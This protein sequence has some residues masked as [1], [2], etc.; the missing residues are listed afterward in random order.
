MRPFALAVLLS[1]AGAAP[2]RSAS[3]ARADL[4]RRFPYGTEN[5]RNVGSCHAFATVSLFEAAI[6]QY[7]GVKVHLSQSDLFVSD[8]VFG[9]T[10]AGL[11]SSMQDARAVLPDVTYVRTKGL[12]TFA[13]APYDEGFLNR[14]ERYRETYRAGFDKDPT[15]TA[16]DHFNN[17]LKIRTFLLG[18]VRSDSRDTRRA[19][20]AADAQRRLIS[21]ATKPFRVRTASEFGARDTGWDDWLQNALCEGHPVAMSANIGCSQAFDCSGKFSLHVFDVVGFEGG[22]DPVYLVRNSWGDDDYRKLTLA[23]LKPVLGALYLE[24]PESAPDGGVKARL[25]ELARHPLA[26]PPER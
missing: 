25:E 15:A 8:T 20:E 10:W 1:L 18:L 4:R 12:A 9:P 22:A 23:E 6:Q 13:L 7:Y 14:Y 26:A 5:Q 2:A 21:D 16:E 24:T 17:G 3:C 19:Q 11:P